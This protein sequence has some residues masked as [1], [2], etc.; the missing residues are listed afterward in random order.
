MA[1]AYYQASFNGLTVGVG[2]DIQ[3]DTG[4]ITGLLGSPTILSG[5]ISKNRADGAFPGLNTL[6]ER[7]FDVNLLVAA[8]QILPIAQV[9]ANIAAAFAPISDPTLLLPFQLWLPSWAR[10]RQI[11]CRPTKF[12]VPMNLEYS[13][14][15]VTGVLEFTAADPL[16]YDSVQSSAGPTGLPSPTAGLTFNATPNFVF[17][18]STGGSMSVS[19]IGNY[20][21]APVW[22]ITGP[23]TNPV[24]TD[25]TTGL[26][27]GVTVTLGTGDVLVIDMG[28]KTV[29]LNGTASRANQML[30]GST[31]FGFPGATTANPTGTRSIGLSSSDSAPVTG[32][33]TAVWRNAWGSTA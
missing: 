15:Y 8:P 20:T 1:L 6:G 26:F 30:Q 22:T 13:F 3:I 12:D 21:T 28:A 27:F 7:I 2:T 25:N 19:N 11:N 31:W 18:A 4:G 24:I 5:D 10:A 9:L 16:I 32:T 29:T 33:F 14:N 23:M 17:G